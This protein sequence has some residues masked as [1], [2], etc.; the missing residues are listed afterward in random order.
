[1]AVLAAPSGPLYAL[2][3]LLALTALPPRADGAP[4]SR[5]QRSSV[6][7]APRPCASSGRLRR[8]RL[9]MEVQAHPEERLPPQENRQQRGENEEQQV[10]RDVVVQPRD[11]DPDDDV[12]GAE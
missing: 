11:H 12:N 2:P 9:L 5:R 6:Q 4:S 10:D 7:A 8:P 1:M 3:S